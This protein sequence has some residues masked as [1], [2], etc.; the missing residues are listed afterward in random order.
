VFFPRLYAQ[1]KDLLEEGKTICVIGKHSDR[2]GE[3]KL[4]AEQVEALTAQ[5]APEIKKKF[6]NYIAAA[7]G[8][9]VQRLLIPVKQNL[10]AETIEKLKEIFKKNPGQTK[11]VLSVGDKKI[12]TGFLINPTPEFKEEIK[13]II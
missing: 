7:G 4:I 8:S 2:E 11:A 10:N 12:D 13:K 3:K 5:N 9:A 6:G 1:A